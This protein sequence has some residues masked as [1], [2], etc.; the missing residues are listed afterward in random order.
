MLVNLACISK[1][2]VEDYLLLQQIQMYITICAII[3]MQM[4]SPSL[5]AA[6]CN[7]VSAEFYLCNIKEFVTEVGFHC[8]LW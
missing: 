4:Q 6:Q 7:T 8:N 1:V 5:A 3:M 2:T